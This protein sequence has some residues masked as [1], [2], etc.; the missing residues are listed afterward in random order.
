MRRNSKSNK[1]W[2]IVLILFFALLIIVGTSI[3]SSRNSLAKINL[4]EVEYIEIIA[5][6]TDVMKTIKNS[7]EIKDI[8]GSLNKLRG[9]KTSPDSSVDAVNYVNVYLVTGKKI[10]FVKG[11]QTIRVNNTWY[12]LNRRNSEIIDKIIDK[13]NVYWKIPQILVTSKGLG[14]FYTKKSIA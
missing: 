11:G 7:K 5:R 13:Y 10:E 9:K 2:R 8:A 3:I 12:Y 4:R 14:D 6:K 1:L